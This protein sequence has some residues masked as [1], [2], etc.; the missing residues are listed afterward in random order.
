VQEVK[1]PISSIEE[2]VASNDKVLASKPD[3][4]QIVV[5]WN[6]A[7]KPS[8]LGGKE[9]EIKKGNTMQLA[10]A[11]PFSNLLLVVRIHLRQ[12]MAGYR[13]KLISCRNRR[14]VAHRFESCTRY[15][16]L[17]SSSGGATDF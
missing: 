16:L 7:D 15:K 17:H 6:L 10:W 8:Y 5:C 11:N 13:L 2:R 9:T 1:C 4:V 14:Q 12:R 3:G